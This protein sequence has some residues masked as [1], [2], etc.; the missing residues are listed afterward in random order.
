MCVFIYIG[1]QAQSL[2]CVRLFVTPW[3]VALPASPFM[4]FSRKEYQ[5]GLPFHSPGDLPDSGIEPLFLASPALVGEFFT[6]LPPG[7]S[8]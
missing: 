4:G 1:V 3:S 7:K 8:T 6:T 5:S 2:S